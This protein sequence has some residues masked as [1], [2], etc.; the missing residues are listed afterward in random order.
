MSSHTCRTGTECQGTL[1]GH[2]VLHLEF[3]SNSYK[4]EE[5]TQLP[6]YSTD[7]YTTYIQ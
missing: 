6:T 1:N 3:T 4:K 2:T 7:V 5:I